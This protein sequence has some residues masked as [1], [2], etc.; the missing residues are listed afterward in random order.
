MSKFVFRPF[1]FLAILSLLFLGLRLYNLQSAMNFGSDAARDFLV[2]W[3]M[4]QTH[5]P[6]LIGPPSE[7]T[8]IGRQFFF[9]PAPYYIILPALIFGN[10]DPLPVSYF[11]I[12]L[13]LAILLI[14]LAILNKNSKEK[15]A[16]YFF[17]LFCTVTPSLVTYSQSYWN[18]NF[19]LPVSILLV[20]LIVKSR[21]KKGKHVTSLFLLIGF[22]FGV[23]MQF[24]YSFIFAIIV[25]CIW[26]FW[27]KTISLQTIFVLLCGFVIGFFPLIL[28]ELRNHFYNLNTMILLL[29]HP[30]AD[31]SGFIFNTFYLVSLLPFMLYWISLF[32]KRINHTFAYIFFAAYTIWSFIVIFTPH[33][34][35]FPYRDAEQIAKTIEND[36][37]TN[38]NVADQL[39]KDNRAEPIRYLLTVH[40]L[41]PEGVT[42][43]SGIKTLYIYSNVPLPLLTKDPVYEIKSFLPYSEVKTQSIGDNIKLYELK[44]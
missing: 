5:H 35:T 10:W 22:L 7:Y 1:V 6:V 25:S 31:N 3:N 34:Q 24:H 26:L 19:M 15:S 20:A 38:F 9:G 40:N 12:V 17:A 37:P 41:P 29:T 43:Y 27:R 16:L 28:F 8:V 4:Y 2:V 21:G 42:D 30:S 36:N 13:N 39:T 18:P 32:L 33:T 14:S 11:L 23:G 44:K